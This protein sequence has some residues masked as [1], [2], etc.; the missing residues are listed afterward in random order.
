MV[1]GDDGHT[2]TIESSTSGDGYAL[3]TVVAGMCILEVADAPDSVSSQVEQT[4][5]L[6]GRQD[7]EW[8]AIEMTYSY[9]PDNGLS[10]VL[11]EK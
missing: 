6:M 1:L 11:T 8:D 5:A 2:L 9:H 7:A 10:A 4:T 3:L